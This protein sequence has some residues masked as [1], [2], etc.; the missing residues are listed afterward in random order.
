MPK[1]MLFKSIQTN[2]KQLEI[3]NHDADEYWING[4]TYNNPNDHSI[5]VLKRMGIGTTV[6]LGQKRVRVYITASLY[7]L[8][9][10]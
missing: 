5:R 7:S 8:Q 4:T 1:L 10:C 3:L 2:K 9:C 6:I